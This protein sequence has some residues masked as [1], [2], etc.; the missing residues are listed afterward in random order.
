MYDLIACDCRCRATSPLLLN[1]L[2]E[3]RSEQMKAAAASMNDD[4]IEMLRMRKYAQGAHFQL[5]WLLLLLRRRVNRFCWCVAER[6]C[7]LC[8]TAW[9]IWARRAQHHRIH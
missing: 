4:K 5:S 7:L 3:N 9:P 2:K 8:M 6:V 1:R